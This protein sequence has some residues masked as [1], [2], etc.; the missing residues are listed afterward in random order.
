MFANPLSITGSIGIYYGKADVTEL[1]KKIGVTVEVYKTTPRADAE[2]LFRP[3]SPDEKREL[4]RKVRQFYD[5]FLSRVA[6]G[7][8]L[9]KKQVD[10]V[11]QGRVWTGEQA[12]ARRLVDEIGGLRQAIEYARHAA[13][14]P[15]YAPIVQL[16]PPQ[17]TLVGQ[18]LGV[19]GMHVTQ[20][21]QVL[22]AQILEVAKAL[23]PFVAHD[24]DEPLALME[25]SPTG[26]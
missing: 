2:S 7:R 4:R 25:F 18:L 1:L 17:H 24:P 14:L 23:A 11:G 26:F 12:Q 13:G 10:E 22:P 21:E 6:L 5:T 20:P 9:S 8:K 3:Y 16:P 19:E 15:D